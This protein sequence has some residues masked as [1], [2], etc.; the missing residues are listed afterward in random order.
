MSNRILPV[1]RKAPTPIA[2]PETVL[3]N[4]YREA[5]KSCR[6]DFNKSLKLGEFLTQ[7]DELE[8]EYLWDRFIQAIDSKFYD[9]DFSHADLWLACLDQKVNPLHIT[10]SLDH[11]EILGRNAARPNLIIFKDG[12]KDHADKGKLCQRLDTILES[13]LDFKSPYEDSTWFARYKP[14]DLNRQWIH[15]MA[16][17]VGYGM[18][19]LQTF[20]I[21]SRHA[22]LF[23][24]THVDDILDYAP[25]KEKSELLGR[26]FDAIAEVGFDLNQ[27]VDNV[28]APK[29][30]GPLFESVLTHATKRIQPLDQLDEFSASSF[31]GPYVRARFGED[32]DFVRI[33]AELGKTG[34]NEIT[35]SVA[36]A[37]FNTPE[38]FMTLASSMDLGLA[39]TLFSVTAAHS[40]VS[41]SADEQLAVL[42]EYDSWFKDNGLG[43]VFT[44]DTLDRLTT[45]L[46]STQML[47]QKGLVDFPSLAKKPYF[48]HERFCKRTEDWNVTLFK[49][50]EDVEAFVELCRDVNAGDHIR[51]T[52]DEMLSKSNGDVRLQSE[53]LKKAFIEAVLKTRVV[54][55]DEVMKTDKRVEKLV[56]M[57]ISPAL[58]KA[59]SRYKGKWLDSSLGSDLGL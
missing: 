2:R 18:A 40:L 49:T 48:Y 8:A 53:P 28:L 12:A 43:T 59:S 32:V 19:K 45:N 35:A 10:H 17:D 27:P 9:K 52:L 47:A 34:I 51:Y 3:L 23:C 36:L 5:T 30:Q 6:L 33:S 31:V 15:L 41:L 7:L 1:S 39:R 25:D 16:R 26:L 54:E 44:T 37:E 50:P 11:G 55:P 58:L 42:N 21:H 4:A 46:H 20:L 22:K 57:G 14:A 24:L 13:A 38:R 56:S 29:D